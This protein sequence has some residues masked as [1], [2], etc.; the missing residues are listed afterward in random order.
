MKANK[1]ISGVNYSQKSKEETPSNN[2][3]DDFTK[4]AI[5]TQEKQ[6]LIEILLP[7][8]YRDWENKNPADDLNEAWLELHQKEE[9]YYIA[10]ADYTIERGEDE[11]TGYATKTIK[12][13]NKTLLFIK[14]PNLKIGQVYAS[15][16]DKDKICPNEKMSFNYKDI[17]YIINAEGDVVSDEEVHTD[18]G[19]ERYCVVEN[20]K[21]YISTNEKN[22]SLFLEQKSFNDTFTKLLFVGDID[23]D[24]KL[25]FIFESNR[26]YEQERVF[27]YLSSEADKS[28]IIKK[29]AEISVDFSC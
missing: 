12:S 18:N 27:L 24:E 26:H 10:K 14:H 20:Y 15:Y 5:E 9:K 11:C 17:I 2:K 21:L 3:K 25:D 23:S 6:R 1:A 16:F 28:E 13:K 19:L 8:T 7:S 29:V 4:K 22:E